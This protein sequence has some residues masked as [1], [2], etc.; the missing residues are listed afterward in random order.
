MQRRSRLALSALAALAGLAGAAGLAAR[1]MTPPSVLAIDWR[2]ESAAFGGIS[3]FDVTPD[4][5]DFVAVGDNGTILAGHLLREGGQL[6][7]IA[8]G[9][10]HWLPAEAGP[11][12]EFYPEDAEGVSLD[13]TGR[14]TIS[15][16]GYTRVWRLAP[17]PLPER[18]E[19]DPAFWRMHGNGSLEAVATLA[20]G[21]ILAMPELPATRDA[22]PV[23]LH[24]ASGWRQP[25]SLARDGFWRAVGADVGPDGRLYLLE[26]QFLG[27]GFMSRIRR[28]DLAPGAGRLPGELLYRSP[29]GRHGNLEGIGIW[30]DGDG[31]LRAVMVSDDNFLPIQRS[32][33][34]EAILAP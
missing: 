1:T 30:R 20:D 17:G 28:F 24:D 21:T 12:D 10:P 16:E 32:Q 5:Q 3:G 14:L 6:V 29:P 15:Y 2:M 27:F 33:V 31:N 23:Y 13:A 9:P 4:G 11:W 22:Y 34:V 8:A 19:Q 18:I 26:R 7:G 25:F